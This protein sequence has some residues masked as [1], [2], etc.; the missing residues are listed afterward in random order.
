VTDEF[1]IP[2]SVLF[3]QFGMF[4]EDP[5]E[6][7]KPFP[8]II[9]DGFAEQFFFKSS[10]SV[11]FQ[12]SFI[13]LL[14]KSIKVICNRKQGQKRVLIF[15]VGILLIVMVFDCIE[16]ILIRGFIHALFSKEP[17]TDI[18]AYMTV[19]DPRIN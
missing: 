18:P 10:F 16:K 5:V 4:Y 8:C 19:P 17:E 9:P 1:I 6:I 13:S 12:V 14:P 3:D 11:Y 15:S 2:L 7:F